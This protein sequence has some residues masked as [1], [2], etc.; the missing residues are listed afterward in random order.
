MVATHPPSKQPPATGARRRPGRPAGRSAADGVLADRGRLLEAAERLIRAEGPG[1]T[2]E[3]IAAE[4]GVTKPMLYRGIGDKDALVQA[5]AERLT[6]AIARE[7]SVAVADATGPLDSLRRLV[8]AYLG[9]ARR[10]RHLY[11][12]V[13]AGASGDDRI[14]EALLLADRSA[15]PLAAG[16]A[17]L[18]SSQRAD[19]TVAT[20][21]A[22]GVI[23][24]LHFVTLWWLREP[25]LDE[26]RL[27]DQLVELLW[28]GF[29]GPHTST[30]R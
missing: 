24:M 3:A 2:L 28:S 8:G 30:G 15:E 14:R 1:V 27:T 26:E 21:W 29:G 9:V 12:Y 19:A 10:D 5:L 4:A 17:A 18:R 20:A 23:G 11:L 13:T 25:V 7:V 22:Y 16:I 6:D